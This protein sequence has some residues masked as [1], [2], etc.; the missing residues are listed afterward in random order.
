MKHGRNTTVNF[1]VPDAEYAD[2]KPLAWSCLT[3][4]LISLYTCLFV[5]ILNFVLADDI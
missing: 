1:Q 3:R 2:T 5:N 4:N